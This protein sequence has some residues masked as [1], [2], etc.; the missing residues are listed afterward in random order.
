MIDGLHR[1]PALLPRLGAGVARA[2][3]RGER[4]PAAAAPTRTAPSEYARQ[5]RRAQDGRLVQGVRRHARTTSSTC[6][7]SSACASGKRA[8]IADST[9]RTRQR[10]AVRG[11]TCTAPRSPA[12]TAPPMGTDPHRHPARHRRGAD[13]IHPGLLDRA[14]D[15][16][17]RAVRLRRRAV[18]DVQRGDPA[19]RDPGGGG[20]VLAAISGPPG[21]A[22]SGSSA[23][24]C[25][26]RATSCSPSCPS[27]MLGLIAQ[28]L[29][30]RA[31]SEARG[32]RLG[33]DRRRHRDPRRIEN[34]L[35]EARRGDDGV[36]ELPLQA[37]RS[38]SAS[39]S[40]CR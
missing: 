27:A 2:A 33:A 11:A 38:A 17:H 37:G 32:G 40:A 36:A 20:A 19:R 10:P 35:A 26:S 7:P 24:G 12:M 23:P 14:P 29:H 3:A 4:P 1:R 8:G 25:C 18:G 13:R 15:P 28:G 31:C 16:R 9:V 6:R 21:W 22:C 34:E 5:R 30:R 39:R